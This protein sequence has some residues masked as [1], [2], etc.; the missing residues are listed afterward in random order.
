MWIA[1]EFNLN[2]FFIKEFCTIMNYYG[3][4]GTDN[5]IATVLKGSLSTAEVYLLSTEVYSG[6]NRTVPG[7]SFLMHRFYASL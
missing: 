6:V 7:L 4:K 2:K 3:V 5:C 1:S